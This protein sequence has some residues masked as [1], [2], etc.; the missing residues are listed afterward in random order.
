[1]NAL[2]TSDSAVCVI[3]HSSYTINGTSSVVSMASSGSLTIDTLAAMTIT[4]FKVSVVVG[5]QT[6]QST[7]LSIEVFDCTKFIS[8][9]N[10]ELMYGQKLSS[11]KYK[12]IFTI[13]RPLNSSLPT[14]EDY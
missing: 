5:S 12:L 13:L 3:D 10:L 11:Q 2:A 4:Y 8:F 1:M 9:P 14:D 7:L 6:I